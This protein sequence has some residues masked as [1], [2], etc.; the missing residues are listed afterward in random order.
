MDKRFKLGSEEI[1]RL[2]RAHYVFF[3]PKDKID[4]P[5]QVFGHITSAVSDK[6][7]AH[8]G[9]VIDPDRMIHAWWTVKMDGIA[10][11]MT[12]NYKKAYFYECTYPRYSH[13]RAKMYAQS[14]IGRLYDIGIIGVILK[15]IYSLFGK[16]YKTNKWD[17]DNANWCSEL[18]GECLTKGQYNVE[19]DGFEKPSDIA[20]L[21]YMR[22]VC[23]V[24]EEQ[25]VS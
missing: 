22:F 3:E 20:G 6:P 10:D 11:I 17:R 16:E 13:L 15:N 8:C 21:P 18:C 2:E 1:K 4:N 12:G 25:I 23:T 9:I 19:V 14:C 5:A 7:Y 24:T